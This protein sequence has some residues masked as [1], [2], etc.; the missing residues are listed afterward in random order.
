MNVLLQCLCRRS[1]EY[2]SNQDFIHN[3]LTILLWASPF[4][5]ARTLRKIAPWCLKALSKVLD[6]SGHRH[7]IEVAVLVLTK[8]AL[9]NYPTFWTHFLADE[10]LV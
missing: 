2:L 8:L 1:V 10:L 6:E 7:P 4:V 5:S 9:H 3:A